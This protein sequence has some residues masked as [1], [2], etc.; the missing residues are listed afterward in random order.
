MRSKPPGTKSTTI[1]EEQEYDTVVVGTEELAANYGT[2]TEIYTE[3]GT[4]LYTEVERI[5]ATELFFFFNV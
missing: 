2:C 3:I 4:E 5:P 1:E